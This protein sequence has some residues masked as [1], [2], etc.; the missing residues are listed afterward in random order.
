MLELMKGD[1]PALSLRVITFEDA[2]L[3]TLTWPHAMMDASGLG[4]LVKAWS[5]VLADPNVP[6]P[7][8]MGARDDVMLKP[9]LSKE[10]RD[11]DSEVARKRLIRLETF[12][13]IFRLILG[14]IWGP[15]N[16]EG[17]LHI[18]KNPQKLCE[19]RLWTS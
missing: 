12:I 11:E 18:S 14:L 17:V 9:A 8:L 16:R 10:A 2:T 13:F 1:H 6:V 15:T 4:A 5:N 19:T 3:V 7:P